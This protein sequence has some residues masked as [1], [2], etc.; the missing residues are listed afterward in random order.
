MVMDEEDYETWI[1]EGEVDTYYKHYKSHLSL[2]GSFTAP[3]TSRYRIIVVNYASEKTKVQ[4]KISL[5][6]Q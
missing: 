1:D 4:I 6:K 5:E 2:N 3:E